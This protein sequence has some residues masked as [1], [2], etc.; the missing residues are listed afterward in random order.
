MYVY[1]K[2]LRY[3]VAGTGSKESPGPFSSLFPHRFI[4]VSANCRHWHTCST[5][6][7]AGRTTRRNKT[8]DRPRPYLIT[9]TTPPERRSLL[10]FRSHCQTE[11]RSYS[12][13]YP[14]HS[15]QSSEQQDGCFDSGINLRET[16]HELAHLSS[17]SSVLAIQ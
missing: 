11:V 12:C 16:K 8:T 3:G 13:M 1:Y 5:I 15:S 7:Q 6:M 14:L 9:L 10:I 17:S 2:L 4:D